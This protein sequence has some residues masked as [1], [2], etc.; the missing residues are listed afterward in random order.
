M[1]MVPKKAK[2]PAQ[3]V[4]AEVSDAQL[5]ASLAALAR[6]YFE[7]GSDNAASA[8]DPAIQAVKRRRKLRAKSNRLYDEIDEK[9][10]AAVKKF[11]PRPFSLIAWREYSAIGAGEIKDRYKLFLRQ[12]RATPETLYAEYLDAQKRYRAAIKAGEDWDKNCGLAEERKRLRFVN[13]ELRQAEKALAN[14]VN[15]AGR[16]CSHREVCCR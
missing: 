6:V 7:A 13:K 16:N 5:A 14:T 12:D 15:L 4:P 10:A 1:P 3:N 8:D 9:E 11:G 2:N